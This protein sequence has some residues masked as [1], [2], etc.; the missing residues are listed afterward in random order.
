[1]IID[2]DLHE[3]DIISIGDNL[4]ARYRVGPLVRN[5]DGSIRAWQLIPLG[6]DDKPIESWDD[7]YDAFPEAQS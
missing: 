7:F 2:A 5:A 3:G 4:E 1:M 6:P